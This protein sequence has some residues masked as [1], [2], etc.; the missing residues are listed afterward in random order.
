MGIPVDD[1]IF[2]GNKE[3]NDEVISPR[4][5]DLIVGKEESSTFK[6]LGIKVEERED[7]ITLIQTKYIEEKLM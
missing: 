3:F 2:E 1:L 7:K 4:T 5:A 6:Y